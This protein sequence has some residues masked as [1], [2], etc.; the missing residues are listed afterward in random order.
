[1]LDG[2]LGKTWGR[3]D[4]SLFGKGARTPPPN[5]LLGRNVDRTQESGGNR[6]QAIRYSFLLG[7]A[8]RTKVFD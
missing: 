6:A 3:P 1:M 7:V 2:D 8:G 4:V 5:S